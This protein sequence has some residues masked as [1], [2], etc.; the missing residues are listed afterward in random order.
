MILALVI[1]VHE[2]GFIAQ[3]QNEQRSLQLAIFYGFQEIVDYFLY[4]RNIPIN[5]DD[6]DDEVQSFICKD[7]HYLNL[8]LQSGFIQVHLLTLQYYMETLVWS[9]KSTKQ[10]YEKVL[11]TPSL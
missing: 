9:R 7:I 5:D 1:F 2:W 6:E 8:N 3:N 10:V 11:T 4:D